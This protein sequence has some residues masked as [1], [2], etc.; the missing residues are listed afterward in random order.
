MFFSICAETSEWRCTSDRFIIVRDGER[1]CAVHLRIGIEVFDSACGDGLVEAGDLGRSLS[2]QGA[3]VR[4][5]E[6]I[7]FHNRTHGL[8]ELLR[9]SLTTSDRVRIRLVSFP[10]A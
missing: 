10:A 3:L 7:D 4:R 6:F 1:R 5:D 9:F 8:F 2:T